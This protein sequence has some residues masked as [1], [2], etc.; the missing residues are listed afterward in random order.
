MTPR[1]RLLLA[2]AIICATA[3]GVVVGTHG[4]GQGR[5]PG[6]TASDLAARLAAAPPAKRPR[7][8]R[9]QRAALA[10]QG[11]DLA[12]IDGGGRVLTGTSVPLVAAARGSAK[13]GERWT[14]V[15]T[16]PGS[17]T[18]VA[19]AVTPKASG[20]LPWWLIAAAGA[21]VLM[22][23]GW[24]VGPP[25]RR[26]PRAARVPR[27][28]RAQRRRR[29][30][31]SS[32]ARFDSLTDLPN[33]MLL[34]E[35][36]ETAIIRRGVDDP[37]SLLLFDLDEFKEV[38]DTLGHFSGDSLL[39]AVATRLAGAV[40]KDGLLARLGGDEFAVLLP[41]G[42]TAAEQVAAD[43]GRLLERPFVIEGM[44]LQLDASI[45]IAVCPDH[46]EDYE[47]LLK[48]A[49]A[50]MY[51]AKRGRT[52]MEVY[53]AGSEQ[54]HSSRLA[55]A[56]DLRRAIDAGELVLEYQPKARIDT[57]EVCG[58]EA[59]VRWDHPER[60]RISPDQFIPLAERSGLIRLLTVWV[61]EHAVGQCR[62]WL[63]DGIRLPVSVN[64]STRDLIDAE[65][66]GQIARTIDRVG[67]DPSLLEVE[68][69]E[70]VLMA[71]PT[72]SREI[73]ARIG[74]LGVAA[75][76]D[77]FGSGYSSLAYLTRLPVQALKIDKSFVL[78]MASDEGDAKIVQAV[79]DLAHNL[80]L[81]VI[82]E[83]VETEESWRRL[84]ALG[85]DLVQGFVLSQ[86]RTPADL[87]SW[88]AHRER[89]AA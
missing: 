14:A 39:R 10:R 18:R 89:T 40:P 49:D 83:G 3:L 41:D 37:V 6:R 43:V 52:R 7:V 36:A 2:T 34:R 47:T 51:R 58:V 85:C 81:Q 67:L 72:R 56:A 20:G 30:A 26:A 33:R 45:G 29:T 57:A 73:V 42:R 75:A 77:D 38:N 17:R 59:L 31:E 63:D 19:V 50:A 24:A 16:V 66:P 69:T 23:F 44:L 48:H 88:L 54:H 71:D 68:I 80:G 79:V 60:G 25:A 35:T 32:I 65:L 11:V 4:P 64:L 13:G 55:L 76:I 86:A 46:A 82:A 22:V 84:Q 61:L 70:S 74:D 21:A 78:N 87:V 5:D 27:E 62:A 12:V 15:R 53:D 28:R 9:N 8:L 1:S